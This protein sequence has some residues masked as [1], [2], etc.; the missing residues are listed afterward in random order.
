MQFSYFW[1]RLHQNFSLP[2]D[3]GF[4]LYPESMPELYDCQLPQAGN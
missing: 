3:L 4:F 1:Y 2:G